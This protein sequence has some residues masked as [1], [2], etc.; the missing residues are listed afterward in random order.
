MCQLEKRSDD[1]REVL[2]VRYNEFIEKSAPMLNFYRENGMLHTF[3]VKR[4]MADTD[5]LFQLMK[6]NL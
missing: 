6:H 3:Q 4:G 2:E 1:T 5:D